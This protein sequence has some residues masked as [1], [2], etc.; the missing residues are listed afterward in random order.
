MSTDENKQVVRRFLR[1]ISSGGD[2]DRIDE[3]VAPNYVNHGMGNV[4]LAGFKAMLSGMQAASEVEM[5]DLIAEGDA[6]VSRTSMKITLAGGEKI[7]A[8]AISFYRLSDGKIAEDDTMT[9]P[10]LAQLLGGAM[11]AAAGA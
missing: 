2:L 11:P 6:V 10:D 8:R 9:T 5:E 3:L 7:S 1:E 4:D